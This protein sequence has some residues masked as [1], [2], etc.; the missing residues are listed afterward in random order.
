MAQWPSKFR[1]L[2][3]SFTEGLPNRVI[4]SNMDVGP[5]K[6]RRRTILASYIINFTTHIEMAD[7]D[8]F[9]Q[10]YLDND[11]GIFDFVH[12]RTNTV[13]KARFNNVPNPIL[14]ETFY[15]ANVELEIMP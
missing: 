12:P 6:K 1:I 11:F 10:F 4:K 7:V 5:A 8:E 15:N 13:V 2:R 14:N 9:R 3:E